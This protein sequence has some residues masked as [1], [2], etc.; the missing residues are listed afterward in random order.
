MKRILIPTDFSTNANNALEYAAEISSLAGAA[1]TLLHVYTPAV[2]S[3]SVISALLTDEVMDAKKDA[4][5][6]LGVLQNTLETEFPGIN[7]KTEVAVGEAVKEILTIARTH[8]IELIIMGTLGA[9]NL[10]RTLFGSNTASVIERSDCPVLCIP[11]GCTF[12]A[13]ER[14][15][16]ATNFSYD[17]IQGILKLIPLA[18]AFK[19]EV[20]VGHINTSTDENSEDASMD[21]FV[22]EVKLATGYERISQ[23]IVSDHNVSMGLDLIVQESNIDLL[24][25]ATHRRNF[26]EKFYNPSLTKKISLYTKI[27]I[28]V[29]QN[30][31]QEGDRKDF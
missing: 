4:L 6:K 2:S 25:L 3:N 31:P 11:A 30:P 17:D 9:T 19:S 8:E 21:K 16:F 22:A 1:I 26:F 7:C 10:T 24:A 15:L 28:A 29:F 23:K 5:T 18:N 27:P 20:V 14:I 13:P 12:Q